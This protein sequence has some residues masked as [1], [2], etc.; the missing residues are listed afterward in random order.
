MK[1]L[2]STDSIVEKYLS[3]AVQSDVP[4]QYNDYKLVNLKELYNFV[5]S[6]YKS[7]YINF[8]EIIKEVIETAMTKGG[9]N[10]SYELGSH[11]TK[12]GNAETINFDYDFEYDEEE[13]ES[14]NHTITF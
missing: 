5:N 12:S 4:F 14:T 3:M 11:E 8:E 7:D 2:L 13:G 6:N 10:Y 9:P 1:I